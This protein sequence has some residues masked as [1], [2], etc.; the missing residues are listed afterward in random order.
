MRR[1]CLVPI[2]I[3]ILSSQFSA[4][5]L[6][7]S[8]SA[9]GFSLATGLVIGPPVILGTIIAFLPPA[10]TEGFPAVLRPLLGNVFVVGISAALVLEHLI[11]RDQKA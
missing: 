1:E 9:E 7:L 11:V 4:G 2:L 10:I 6:I 3:Y 8:E 5:L